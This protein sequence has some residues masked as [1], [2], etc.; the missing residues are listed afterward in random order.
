[1]PL[2]TL[3]RLIDVPFYNHLAR[4]CLFSVFLACLSVCLLVITDSANATQQPVFLIKWVTIEINSP[5]VHNVFM[6]VSLFV[7]LLCICQGFCLF[8]CLLVKVITARLQ[9]HDLFLLLHCCSLIPDHRVRLDLLR[10]RRYTR[11]IFQI[12]SGMMR[13]LKRLTTNATTPM[14]EN[15]KWSQPLCL[16]AMVHYSFN[17]K[18]T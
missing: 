8:V 11:C 1:M 13:M 9:F 6:F 14:P 15:K 2:W 16:K 4:I 5:V 3:W 12:K 17:W 7:C 18:T 10:M